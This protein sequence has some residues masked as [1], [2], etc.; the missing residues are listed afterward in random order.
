[1]GSSRDDRKDLAKVPLHD[2]NNAAKGFV[3]VYKVM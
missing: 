3:P 2:K 1:M